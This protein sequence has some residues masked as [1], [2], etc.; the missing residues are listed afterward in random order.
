MK[1]R[2]SAIPR[3]S[4][5]NVASEIWCGRLRWRVSAKVTRESSEQRK[6]DL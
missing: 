5:A 2:I 6:A 4:E 3:T 1:H